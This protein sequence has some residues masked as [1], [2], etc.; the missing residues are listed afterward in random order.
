M[1]TGA[2]THR[3]SAYDLTIRSAF[4]LPEL[5][6]A[7]DENSDVEFVAGDVDPV[8]DADAIEDEQGRRIAVTPGACR[9][10]YDSIGS[11]LVESGERVVCDPDDDVADRD[12]FLRLLE[13]ELLGLLMLQRDCLVLHASAVSVDGRAVAFLGPRGAGKST[14]AAAFDAADH[15]MLEDD[16]VAIRFDDDGPTVVPGVPQIRLR[17]DA[18]AALDLT[19]SSVPSPDSWYDKRYL[20]TAEIPDPAPLARCYVLRDGEELALEEVGGTDRVLELVTRTHARGLLEDAGRSGSH[21]EQCSRVVEAA[22][23]RTLSRP[24]DHDL[25]PSLVDLVVEDLR[26]NAARPSSSG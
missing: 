5:P 8:T 1:E 3:Y 9:L 17:S 20:R 23:F 12:L 2:R 7:D 10:T 21:F 19:D 15:P 13:N 6:D 4:E 11:F 14:T 18:A 25:L 24:R 22:P 16:V 26:S